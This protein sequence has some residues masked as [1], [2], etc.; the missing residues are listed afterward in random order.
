MTSSDKQRLASLPRSRC[1]KCGSKQSYL[2]SMLKCYECDKKF[3]SDHI[4]AS[5]MNDTVKKTDELR[6]ICDDCQKEHGYKH[7]N[8]YSFV[9]ID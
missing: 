3:C 8:D 2:N 9:N 1:A 6:D 4:N 7:F 5:Q